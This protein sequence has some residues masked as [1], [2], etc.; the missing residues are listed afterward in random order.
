MIDTKNIVGWS[1]AKI[2][3]TVIVLRIIRKTVIKHE[4][5]IEWSLLRFYVK[6]TV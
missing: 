6:V 4:E 5:T 1:D 2:N 3:I